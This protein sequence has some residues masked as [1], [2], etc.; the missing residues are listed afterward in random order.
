MADRSTVLG[1]T[2]AHRAQA[3]LEPAHIASAETSQAHGVGPAHGTNWQVCAVVN[4]CIRRNLIATKVQVCMRIVR[5]KTTTRIACTLSV[6]GASLFVRL[7]AGCAL[8]SLQTTQ[9]ALAIFGCTH[10]VTPAGFP[11]G[12]LC[13]VGCTLV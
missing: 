13:A 7:C 10:A 4:A 3:P 2:S 6:F 9:I 8:S 12:H 1:P 5:G 11:V